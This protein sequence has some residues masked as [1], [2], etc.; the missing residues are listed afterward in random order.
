MKIT[1]YTFIRL[2]ATAIS[3]N[4]LPLSIAFYYINKQMNKQSQI[5]SYMPPEIKIMELKAHSIICI[6]PGQGNDSLYE[7]DLGDGGFSQPNYWE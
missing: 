2:T 3:E 6:S 1:I 5:E 4:S 7:Q